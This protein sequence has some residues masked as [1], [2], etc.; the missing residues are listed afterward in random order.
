MPLMRQGVTVK[1]MREGA[2][3]GMK[4]PNLGCQV[5]RTYTELT[6]R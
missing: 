5:K 4:K 3:T 2:R 1:I 6:I